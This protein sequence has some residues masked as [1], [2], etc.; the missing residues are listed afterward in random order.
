MNEEKKQK[1]GL[2]RRDFMKATGGAAAV[3]G[4]AGGGLLLGPKT[5]GASEMPKKWDEEFDVVIIGSGFAGLAA[6]IEAKN[7]GSSAVILE[8]MRVPGG[9]SI[10]NGGLL[11]GA[12]TPLQDKEGIKDSPEIMYEDT[13]K[14]GLHLNH[15]ELVRTFCEKSAETIMW[16]VEYLGVEY[17]GRVTHLGGHAVPRSYFTTVSSGAGIVRPMLDKVKGLG[18]ELRTQMYLD[19]LLKDEDGR[20][21]GVKIRSGYVFPKRESGSEKVIKAKKAVILATGGFGYDIPFRTIQDPRLTADV[22]C[23][24]QPGATAEGLIEAL[25]LGATPVQISWIQLGPWASPDEKGLGI[26]PFFAI[27]AAFTYGVVVDPATGQRFVNELADRKIRADAILKI[28][29]PAIGLAD[30]EGVKRVGRLDQMLERGVVK[31]F[32]TLDELAV[33][34]KIDA[35]GLK[36]TVAKYNAYLKKGVDEEFGRPFQKDAKAME[37]PPFYA[38][39]LWPKIHHTMGGIQINKEAQVIDLTHQPIKGLYGA[40]EVTGGVHGAVR[41]GSNA[42]TE[43]LVF[44]RIAGK[45]AAQEQPWG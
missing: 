38:I 18:L 9:N 28:G 26:G 1:K 24:N 19:K 5:A 21:K 20:V 16:T 37:H 7:A 32:P 34:Y 6:A 23:T 25:R 22:D 31:K 41:L 2:S 36:E 15:P 39:R 14:A 42:T 45:K 43:C 17:Q 13:L 12:G 33:A 4:L 10:I 44:G 35:A 11:A 3:A 40:G 8:K 27:S 29:H 30:E